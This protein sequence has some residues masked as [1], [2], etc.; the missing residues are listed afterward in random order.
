MFIGNISLQ[1]LKIRSRLLW[2]Y[3]AF[4]ACKP[5]QLLEKKKM[6]YIIKNQLEEGITKILTMYPT[7]IKALRIIEYHQPQFF[8]TKSASTICL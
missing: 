3:D 6:G 7:M 1:T 4:R 2:L 5:A 8:R